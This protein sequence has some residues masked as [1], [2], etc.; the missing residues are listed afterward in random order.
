MKK[1]SLKIYEL[2]EGNNQR[3]LGVHTLEMLYSEKKYF[4]NYYDH[5]IPNVFDTFNN[6][7][8]IKN[9]FSKYT[10]NPYLVLSGLENDAEEEVFEILN[11][12]I[13]PSLWA[14][15]KDE[16]KEVKN[17]IKRI[18]D[19]SKDKKFLECMLFQITLDNNREKF[20]NAHKAEELFMLYA[21]EYAIPLLME[22]LKLNSQLANRFKDS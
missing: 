6:I 21:N 1:D 17:M 19:P 15:S 11:N 3:Y 7:K 5:S 12:K 18:K 10:L 22:R 8:S 9:Y 16:L 4:K 14:K 20:Y 13:I 2:F